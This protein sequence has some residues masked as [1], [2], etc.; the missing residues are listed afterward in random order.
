M[1]VRLIGRTFTP[2]S[3][4]APGDYMLIDAGSI[5]GGLGANVGGT[6]DG[7]PATLAVQGN[8]VVLHVVPEPATLALLAGGA[9]GW[10][11]LHRLRRGRVFT[12]NVLCE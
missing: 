3:G 8:D 9:I 4:F 5:S 12:R 2:L 10:L 7:L 1:F 11:R 6:I